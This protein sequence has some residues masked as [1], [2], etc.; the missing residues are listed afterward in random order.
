[1]LHAVCRCRVWYGYY[2]GPLSVACCMVHVVWCMLRLF[3]VVSCMLH[4]V[5]CRPQ[6]CIFSVVRDLLHCCMW[7]VATFSVPWHR[8]M[9]RLV[10]CM[11][12]VAALSVVCCNIFSPVLSVVCRLLQRWLFRVARS[13]LSVTCCMSSV[14]CCPL[15]VVHCLLQRFR[16]MLHVVGCMLQVDRCGP[17]PV[18]ARCAIN[19]H[20]PRIAQALAHVHTR[21][22]TRTRT[23]TSKTH[24]RTYIPNRHTC[25]DTHTHPPSTHARTC[26]YT[27]A[28][29]H[30]HTCTHARTHA[31]TH[32]RTQTHSDTHRHTNRH[33]RARTHTHTHMHTRAHT[34]TGTRARTRTS[35]FGEIF[36]KL[37][38]DLAA[39]GDPCVAQLVQPVP[40]Q[41]RCRRVATRCNHQCHTGAPTRPAASARR[42]YSSTPCSARREYSS[43]PASA[44]REYSSTPFTARRDYSST[45]A[46]ARRWAA[47]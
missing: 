36:D 24:T 38:A 7:A 1:M 28:R 46:S 44:R 29:T 21:T 23:H 17:L 13:R 14:A 34:R 27:H 5:C 12:S 31:R 42:E 20:N 35:H 8:C 4:V 33:T 26:A 39:L 15:H 45:P 37:I 2:G 41:R 18:A 11:L 22:Q 30:T 6:F 10:R 32:T 40:L 47:L 16:W 19:S 9:L 3:S 25:I 43:T